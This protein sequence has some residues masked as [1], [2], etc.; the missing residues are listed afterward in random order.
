MTNSEVRIKLLEE[1]SSERR[2]VLSKIIVRE[3]LD[4]NRGKWTWLRTGSVCLEN[5]KIVDMFLSR[6]E[7]CDFPAKSSISY[8]HDS[9][10]SCRKWLENRKLNHEIVEYALSYA[11]SAINQLYNAARMDHVEWYEIALQSAIKYN[12]MLNHFM[13]PQYSAH[14][15]TPQKIWKKAEDNE[16]RALKPFRSEVNLLER[17]ARESGYDLQ[18]P[19]GKW[20]AETEADEE[21]ITSGRLGVL[22]A[23]NQTIRNFDNIMP[24]ETAAIDYCHFCFM[25]PRCDEPTREKEYNRTWLR[26]ANAYVE[27]K[28]HINERRCEYILGAFKT[29]HL[30]KKRI[31]WG[32]PF[33]PDHYSQTN[34][35]NLFQDIW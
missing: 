29:I 14:Y 19:L 35:V 25:H 8:P 20:F 16:R 30:D 9:G 31:E 17:V 10:E 2:F 7:G 33:T 26:V 6:I 4:E 21:D 28:I 13:H 15:C 11:I 18:D 1:L 22:V 3:L 34:S 24:I 5:E 23:R 32:L 27:N 12:A